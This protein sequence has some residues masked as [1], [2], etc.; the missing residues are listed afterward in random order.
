M[1]LSA[2]LLSLELPH[3]LQFPDP[4]LLAYLLLAPS[5]LVPLRIRIKFLPAVMAPVKQ[6]VLIP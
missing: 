4:A 5:A 1:P 3:I 6:L 2:L